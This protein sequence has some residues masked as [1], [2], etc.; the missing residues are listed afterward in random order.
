MTT[1]TI[2][3]SRPI[4]PAKWGNEEDYEDSFF[5]NKPLKEVVAND[6]LTSEWWFKTYARAM[7]TARYSFGWL[8]P[9]YPSTLVRTLPQPRIDHIPHPSTPTPAGNDPRIVHAL[10]EK[11]GEKA[12]L[13]VSIKDG[14]LIDIYDFT[15]P[16]LKGTLR[17]N[18]AQKDAPAWLIRAIC[19]LRIAQ[20]GNY[21]DGLGLKVHDTLYYL[22]PQEDEEDGQ[23]KGE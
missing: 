8:D 6:V 23:K 7:G 9:R 22:E 19:T 5:K 1:N 14:D 18:I 12:A 4:D 11:A 21:I 20:E 17:K 16:N 15:L 3:T 10:I 2:Y 13:R